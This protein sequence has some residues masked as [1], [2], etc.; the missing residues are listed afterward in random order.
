ML[1]AWAPR[2]P[3]RWP[4]STSPR[5]WGRTGTN[6]P[7]N[8]AASAARATWARWSK[9]VNRPGRRSVTPGRRAA[10]DVERA[11]RQRP[12]DQ[13]GAH[14]GSSRLPLRTSAARC[15]GQRLV[16]D[17]GADVDVGGEEA[18]H[19]E[20]VL[21][22]LEQREPLVGQVRVQRA[23]ELVAVRLHHAVGARARLVLEDACAPRRGASA[24]Q[25]AARSVST[26]NRT[27]SSGRS[28]S[29]R[30][31]TVS[32]RGVPL[33]TRSRRSGSGVE[34]DRDR[35]RRLPRPPRPTTR[36]SR[37]RRRPRPSAR[38]SSPKIDSEPASVGASA[39][40]PLA[41]VDLDEGDVVEGQTRR[42]TA[43]GW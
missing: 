36:P 16:V 29:S 42:A 39:G 33:L 19:E 18:V 34:V 43:R 32:G 20:E 22:L 21:L 23:V 3:A 13:S 6:T 30:W 9:S 28:S 10:P 8:P 37:R 41:V 1:Q 11:R 40:V 12:E 27:T 4:R 38:R 2:G 24:A 15:H 25:S 31:C 5:R 14:D 17:P 26:R 35:R 7:E